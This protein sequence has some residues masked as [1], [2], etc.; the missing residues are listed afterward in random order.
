MTSSCLPPFLAIFNPSHF[1]VETQNA[2][3]TS[4][5]TTQGSSLNPGI[6]F[7]ILSLFLS[8]VLIPFWFLVFPSISLYNA[9]LVLC[10]LSMD[11]SFIQKLADHKV[12]TKYKS[13]TKKHQHRKQGATKAIESSTR[14]N[15]L[16]T[17]FSRRFDHQNTLHLHAR[18]TL[19]SAS[20][21]KSV[22][23]H[24]LAPCH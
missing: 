1:S 12:Q 17:D 15:I 20:A 24:Q 10:C 8:L 21:V 19:L 5:F 11:F 22:F 2:P 18:Q 3:Y 9:L 6:P 23:C 16:L 14:E 7:C 13:Q 4:P